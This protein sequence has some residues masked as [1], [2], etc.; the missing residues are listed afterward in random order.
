M[1]TGTALN[2]VTTYY[3]PST[4][5]YPSGGYVGPNEEVSVLWSEGSWYYIEYQTSAGNKRMYVQS[6]GISN[7][8]GNVIEYTP[9]LA[10]RY[11]CI[12]ESAS[13]SPTY[14]GPGTEYTSAGS[15]SLHETVYYLSTKSWNNFYLVEYNISG[16]QKKR[17]WVF[18]NYLAEM[19]GLDTYEIVDTP[20]AQAAY[21]AGY[22]FVTRY[23]TLNS[24]ARPG[25]EA[26]HLSRAEALKICAV[27]L[28]LNAFFEN[29]DNNSLSSFSAASGATNAAAA[30]SQATAVGQP[31]GTHI[32]F[33]VECPATSSQIESNIKPYFQSIRA[34]FDDPTTNPNNYQV[35]IY[36]SQTICE[37]M[38]PVTGYG[39]ASRVYLPGA[40]SWSQPSYTTWAF[41]QTVDTV[42][43][44]GKL[45]QRDYAK[46][47]GNGWTVE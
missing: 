5:T 44:D 37:A 2:Q 17:A 21:N 30:I 28:K 29:G 1:A 33:G 4:T 15:V 32:Y 23:Y 36:A 26:P 7:I 22:R 40:P 31:N 8:S 25:Y 6:S 3:G 27:G 24:P 45:F 14:T 35:G 12:A 43:Y 18:S 38:M 9:V 39:Y 41:K 42:T 34:Y 47:D 16:G 10:T 19:R 20:Q 13:N 11:V 46:I